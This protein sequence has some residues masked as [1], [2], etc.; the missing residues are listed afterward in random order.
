ML[1]TVFPGCKSHLF[2]ISRG[3]KGE[4]EASWI[5]K[6]TRRIISIAR[7]SSK[8]GKV[9]QFFGHTVDIFQ[10]YER[11]I[12]PSPSRPLFH[13]NACREGK[14]IIVHL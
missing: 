14:Y 4:K 7:V 10:F 11:K 13:K 3:R 9:G 5:W 1:D 12:S 6:I 2:I 8:L